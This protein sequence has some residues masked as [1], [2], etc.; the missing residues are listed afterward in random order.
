MKPT[1]F[2]SSTY[3]DLKTERNEI[4]KFCEKMGY[5]PMLSE[6]GDIAYTFDIPLDES[7]YNSVR[8][9][10]DMF[11]LIVGGRYGS[12]SSEFKGKTDEHKFHQRYESITLN[13]YKC[14]REKTYQYLYSSI[15]T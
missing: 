10:A 5:Q 4:S 6:K 3:Y 8:L 9:Y 15:G 7:C 13:E 1:I 2:I 12:P 11:V 14:A